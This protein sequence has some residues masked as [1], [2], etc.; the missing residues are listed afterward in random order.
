M[1]FIFWMESTDTSLSK[2]LQNRTNEGRGA[3]RPSATM[4]V[5]L[6]Q[7]LLRF[8]DILILRNYQLR[9]VSV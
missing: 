4:T 1:L 2:N 6:S 5:Y 7:K 9:C 8:D 3:N